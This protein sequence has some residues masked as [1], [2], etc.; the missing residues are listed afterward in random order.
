MLWIASFGG[1]P[2]SSGVVG[3][4]SDLCADT[5][6]GGFAGNALISRWAWLPIPVARCGYIDS[7]IAVES[8]SVNTGNTLLGGLSASILLASSVG[9]IRSSRRR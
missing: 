5:S 8:L 3:S 1:V 6:I 2:G 4:V 9:L 7:D